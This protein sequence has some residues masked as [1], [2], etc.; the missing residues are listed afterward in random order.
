MISSKD[1]KSFVTKPYPKTPKLIEKLLENYIKKRGFNSEKLI[2]YGTNSRDIYNPTTPF[3]DNKRLFMACRVENR[4]PPLDSQVQFFEEKNGTWATNNET[5]TFGLEDP[6]Y[7]K[8]NG[9]FIFGGV[10]AEFD[11]S[12]NK[13]LNWVTKFYK[14]KTVSDLEYFAQGPDKM[15][16]IRLVGLS[17]GKVG[18]FTR[19]QGELGGSGRIGY[20]VLDSLD[21][22]KEADF[23]KAELINF[24]LPKHVWIGSNETLLLDDSHIGVL[25]HIAYKTKKKGEP[26]SA[27]YHSMMFVFNFNI[28]TASPINIIS[29]RSDFPEGVSKKSPLLDDVIFSGGLFMPLNKDSVYLYAGLSDTEI[30]KITIMNPFKSFKEFEYNHPCVRSA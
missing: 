7:T 10:Q 20:M 6:F 30:G 5:P 23:G 28:K 26:I 4:N 27:H 15:K 2:F 14:G 16:D 1:K 21:E 24:N 9:E 8:I 11:E 3:Y 13:A 29:T 22:L 17:G 25:G 19:P 18:I 12:G